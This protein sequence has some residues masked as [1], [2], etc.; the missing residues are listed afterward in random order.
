MT[1]EENLCLHSSYIGIF[2]EGY[3]I[4]IVHEE[5][6]ETQQFETSPVKPWRTRHFLPLNPGHQV[7]CMKGSATSLSSSLAFIVLSL[8]TYYQAAL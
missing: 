7:M 6:T 2:S 1:L 5:C 3:L 8:E 4:S